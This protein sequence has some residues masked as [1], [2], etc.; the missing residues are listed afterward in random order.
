M[1]PTEAMADNELLIW[2]CYDCDLNPFL[3][4]IP[5][6][7][8]CNGSNV[9]PILDGTEGGTGLPIR[10]NSAQGMELCRTLRFFD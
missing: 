7:D 1:K 9:A 6:C 2:C 5:E 4:S 10:A 3:A 8:I